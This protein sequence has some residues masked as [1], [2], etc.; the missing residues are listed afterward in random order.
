MIIVMKV[1]LK[2]LNY[3]ILVNYLFY[4]I[5]IRSY[6]ILIIFKYWIITSINYLIDN[7]S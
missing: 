4:E 5:L 3:Y 2:K 6:N 1:P 7:Y